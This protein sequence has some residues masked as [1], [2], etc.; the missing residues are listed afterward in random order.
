M[1]LGA[2]LHFDTSVRIDRPVEEVF[3]FLAD[4]TRFPI[5]NSAVTSVRRTSP[6][7]YAMQRDLPTGRAGNELE[8]VELAP[9][10]VFAIRTTSGPTPFEYRYRLRSDAGGTVVAVDA[11][12]QLGGP[13]GLLGPI[14]G[15]AVRRGVDANLATLRDALEAG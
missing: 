5:W 9:P 12:V 11:Q 10:E 1:Y 2:M 8:V 7:T 13:A 4:P 3:G 14:A 15:R 6:T